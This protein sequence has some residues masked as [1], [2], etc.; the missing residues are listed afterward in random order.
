[1]GV[2]P[3]GREVR[4]ERERGFSFFSFFKDFSNSFF[5][6]QSNK[7]PCIWFMMHNPLSFLIY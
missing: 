3:A 5:K 6:L 1:M 2:G 4:E 7:K